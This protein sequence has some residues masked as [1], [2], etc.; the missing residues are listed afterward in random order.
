MKK[1]IDILKSD[2]KPVYSKEL[3]S[4]QAEKV[5]LEGLSEGSLNWAYFSLV[6]Q[7]RSKAEWLD[8]LG[9][10]ERLQKK[11]GLPVLVHL[12]AGD[13][14]IDSLLPFVAL[15]AEKGLNNFL[16]VGGDFRLEEEGFA[17]AVD[18]LT[19]LKKAGG[20][21]L[22]LAATVDP[23]KPD[24]EA[25]LRNFLAKQAA[26][27]DFFISQVTFAKEPLL[28]LKRSVESKKRLLPPVTVGMLQNPSEGQLAFARERLGL[29][30]PTA[31][32]KNARE[33]GQLVEK[34]LLQAG[35]S[36][37]HFFTLPNK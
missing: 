28:D 6:N 32:Q 20:D 19:A 30:V 31:F 17:S 22:C 11:H 4:K 35:F 18:L 2:K 10:A 29:F 36:A 27:A 3:S 13:L 16:V 37:F 7:A 9:L 5:L 26:G 21:S 15:A 25:L 24:Q 33:Q 12:R 14:S 1:I 8:L 23:T 34:A